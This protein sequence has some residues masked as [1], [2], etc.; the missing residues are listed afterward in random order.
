M[1]FFNFTNLNSAITKF[2][3][4]IGSSLDIQPV[5]YCI[6]LRHN[7]KLFLGRSNVT[8][9]C[10]AGFYCSSM[11]TKPQPDNDATGGECP[12]GFWCGK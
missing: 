10:S 11:A 9:P 3:E 6:M 4:Q 1:L 7:S 12:A 5:G 2:G 8:G